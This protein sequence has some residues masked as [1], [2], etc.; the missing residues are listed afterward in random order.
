MRY[1]GIALSLCLAVCMLLTACTETAVES[2]RIPVQI[3][4]LAEG[5][6]MDETAVRLYYGYGDMRLLAGE[7]RRIKVPANESIEVSLLS[8][9]IKEGPSS[10]TGGHTALISPSTT[11]SSLSID[12]QFATVTFSREFLDPYLQQGGTNTAEAERTRRFLAVYSVV[13][14]LIE[15]GNCSRVRIMIDEG[16]GAGRPLTFTEAG[17]PGSGDAQPFERNGDIELNPGV[18][19]RTLLS[20]VE[21]RDWDQ[22]YALVAYR[23]PRGQ[24][25]PDIEAFRA[26]VENARLTL[27]DSEVL[28]YVSTA[29]GNS[30]IVMVSYNISSSDTGQRQ[31]SNVPKRLILEDG[32]WKMTWNVFERSFV[33][34]E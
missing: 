7:D 32:V 26:Q 13:N 12:G 1:S 11:V 2:S 23:N 27:S 3:N 18:A 22:A 14:T 31:F 15:Q 16:T 21:R 24:D 33:T 28:D 6:S 25:R 29:D 20:A 19:M 34:P 17:L 10:S 9:L 4:P 30:V 8:E 5:V